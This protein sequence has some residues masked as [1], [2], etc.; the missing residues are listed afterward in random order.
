MKKALA[1]LSLVLCLV[2]C[3]SVALAAGDTLVVGNPIDAVSL[4]P[5]RTNDAA[6]ARPMAQI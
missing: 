3:A 1:I 4:D 6:S 5:H 2:L